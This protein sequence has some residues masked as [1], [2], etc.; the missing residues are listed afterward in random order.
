MMSS[1]TKLE[2]R[3]T[4]LVPIHDA[5]CCFVPSL[6][7]R[8]KPAVVVSI[9]F[10]ALIGLTC[11]VASLPLTSFWMLG[12]I[13]GGFIA[14]GAIPT[15]RQTAETIDPREIADR[16]VGLAYRA[17][18]TAHTE[19]AAALNARCDCSPLSISLVDSSRDTVIECGQLARTT[20]AAHGYLATHDRDALV[21][22]TARL[23]KQA[24]ATADAEASRAFTA[25]ADSK[26]KLLST[27]TEL[28]GRR[29]RVRARVELA[30]ASLQAVTAKVVK[31]SSFDHETSPASSFPE[32]AA[33]M[34]DRVEAL[35]SMNAA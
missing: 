15:R 20:N 12:A 17:L 24:A 5:T 13:I 32:H 34:S 30:T 8:A 23:R 7:D 25:A 11:V 22:E 31:L 35:E 21:A 3:S 16:D 28:L 4:A 2:P 26:I 33:E 27:V 9:G 6:A 18:L 14:L 1:P 10:A 19:L 29:D